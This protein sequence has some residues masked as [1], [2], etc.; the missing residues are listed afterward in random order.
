MMENTKIE[1]TSEDVGKRIYFDIDQ[2][3]LDLSYY[4]QGKL[5]DNTHF[6]LLIN[7]TDFNN[8]LF[9]TNNRGVLIINKKDYTLIILPNGI[10]LDVY[11]S[12]ISR[13]TVINKL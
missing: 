4:F 2:K 6:I 12:D 10:K 3:A 7:Q 9:F 11:I 5:E 1:K 8:L 13:Y